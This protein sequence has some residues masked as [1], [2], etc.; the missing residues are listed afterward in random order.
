MKKDILANYISDIETQQHIIMENMLMT[1][2]LA[3]EREARCENRWKKERFI[4]P[5]TYAKYKSDAKAKEDDEKSCKKIINMFYKSTDFS[6]NY[7]NSK[8]FAA[9]DQ[10]GLVYKA[11]GLE[12]NLA[13]QCKKAKL[14][15]LPIVRN[16]H[17]LPQN[18]SS[19]FK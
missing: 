19:C 16:M 5:E 14:S 13:L 15:Q 2:S 8:A 4:A 10:L 3:K 7:V 17:V 12:D 6:H 11:I 1:S 9:N 18:S